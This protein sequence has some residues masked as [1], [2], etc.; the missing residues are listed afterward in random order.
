MVVQVQSLV[1]R[2][3]GS[4]LL[5][6]SCK[7]DPPVTEYRWS[8]SQRGR[9]VHV[10]QRTHTVRLFNVTRDMRVRCTAQNAIGRAESRPTPLNV[11]C[12]PSSVRP[13]CHGRT[14]GLF[15]RTDQRA[16]KPS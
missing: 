10:H 12:N 11:Q 9:T 8:Y 7:A 15:E 1:V 2:E 13:A 14:F 5:V 3:G 4:A 6:C 16:R